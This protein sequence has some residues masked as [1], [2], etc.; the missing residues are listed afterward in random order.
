MDDEDVAMQAEVD[1]GAYVMIGVTDTG[2]GIA[3]ETLKHV[4]E[5]FFTTKD[6]GKGS[7]LGLSMVYG[8]AKQS[9]GTVTIESE[10]GVGTTV[11]LYLPRSP[12]QDGN[13]AMAEDVA[14]YPPASTTRH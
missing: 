5:P 2:C 13:A 4:F 7:G 14:E 10:P 1:P 3:S 6:V 11:N 9:G 12:A 8:F